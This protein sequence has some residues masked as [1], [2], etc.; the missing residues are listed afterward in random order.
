MANNPMT[1]AEWMTFEAERI[2]SMGLQTPEEHRADYMLIQIETALHKAAA[3]YRDGLTDDDP[4][5][6]LW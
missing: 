5:R 4:P 1:F 3:H 6:P 2:V